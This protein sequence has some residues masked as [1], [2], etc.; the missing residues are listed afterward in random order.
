[1]SKHR[2]LPSPAMVVAIVALVMATTAT[3]YAASTIARNSV[4]TAQLKRNAVVGSKVRDGSLRAADFGRGQLPAGAR[5]AAGVAGPA[6]PAGA[7][8]SAGPAG[9]AGT[10]GPQGP[11]G[12]VRATVV[13][14]IDHV[15]RDGQS[16][17][18][19]QGNIECAPGETA[20]AG[21]SN[22]VPLAHGDARFSGSGPRNGTVANPTVPRADGPDTWTIWRGTAINPAGGDTGDV[23][24]RVYI[25][26]AT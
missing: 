14:R 19:D 7:R 11:A 9:P 21:G 10:T 13:R 24:V 15:L 2:R 22:Y 23:T 18:A 16:T 8:G 3:G 12:V 4:G 5:G 25:I 26:C 17:A 1:M 20:I 6:G